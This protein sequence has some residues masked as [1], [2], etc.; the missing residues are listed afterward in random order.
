VPEAQEVTA[1]CS[2]PADRLRFFRTSEEFVPKA[3]F[4][5]LG[6]HDDDQ[7][8]LEPIEVATGE[9]LGLV[10]ASGFM[11]ALRCLD[12]HADHSR[13]QL[14]PALA[15]R[16]RDLAAGLHD[17][18]GGY[19]F[20]QDTRRYGEDVD[21]TA[22]LNAALLL[23]GDLSADAN[24]LARARL[25][26]SRVTDRGFSVWLDA[27]AEGRPLVFDAVVD[28][29]V[30]GALT[31]LGGQPVDPHELENAATRAIE[32]CQAGKGGYYQNLDFV[33]YLSALWRRLA[34][35]PPDDPTATTSIE[36]FGGE[37]V[38]QHRDGRIGYILRCVN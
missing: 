2:D 19:R 21:T 38:F 8:Y 37:I 13:P 6:R 30:V 24:R 7:V 31:L 32:S 17:G 18:R 34:C 15:G 12:R 16:M 26:S 11:T 35:L 25:L 14:A 29:N 20:F 1:I 36:E 27:A 33:R 3:R 22:L 10:F 28:L 4:P 5:D 9:S 23:N